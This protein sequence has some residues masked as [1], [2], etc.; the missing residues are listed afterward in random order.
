MYINSVHSK[1]YTSEDTNIYGAPHV[2][3]NAH[4]KNTIRGTNI[5]HLGYRENHI[6]FFV[7]GPVSSLEGMQTL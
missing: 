1:V 3:G 2:I 7:R 5:S 6:Q 4:D